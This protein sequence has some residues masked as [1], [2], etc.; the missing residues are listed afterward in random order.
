MTVFGDPD[1]AAIV[2]AS[3]TPDA[4]GLHRGGRGGRQARILREAHRPRQRP[5]ARV[6]REHRRVRHQA[7]RRVQPALRSPLPAPQVRARRGRDR[8]DRAA[9]HHLAGPGTTPRRLHPRIGRDLPGHDH[10]RL[11]PRPL[12]ARRGA[13]RDLGERLRPR[14]RRG[15]GPRRPRHHHRRDADG[16]RQARGHQQQPPLDLRLRPAHRGARERRHPLRRQRAGIDRGARRGP[17]LHQP[18]GDALL[19]G[20]LLRRLSGG[21]G[22]L[23]QTCWTARSRP[24]RPARTAPGRSRWPTPPTSLSRPAGASPSPST[25]AEP[26]ARRRSGDAGVPYSLPGGV[27]EP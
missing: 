8:A 25:D 1:V 4:L 22:P 20:T 18:E 19:P 9:P 6:P 24:L 7:H 15:R 3:S 21:V 5:R 17:R 12:P 16:K 11:R 2:I 14:R 10:P 13:H 27:G 26:S 23:R